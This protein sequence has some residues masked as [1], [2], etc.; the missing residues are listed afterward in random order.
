[1]RVF[2]LMERLSEMPA[3][4]TVEFERITSVEEL[5]KNEVI[6]DDDGRFYNF[7]ANVSDVEK[8]S[9]NCVRIYG[10]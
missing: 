10:G 3:G 8:I 7:N 2:E 9:D 6:M 4:A 1:M 5:V